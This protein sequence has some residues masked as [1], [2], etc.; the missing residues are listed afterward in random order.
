[1]NFLEF[2]RAFQRCF[3]D[4]S[5]GLRGLHGEFEGRLRACQRISGVSDELQGSQLGS[6]GRF[7]E[8]QTT[9]M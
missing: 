9:H 3:R 2:A 7:R 1:M 8:S 5:G 4:V 6:E